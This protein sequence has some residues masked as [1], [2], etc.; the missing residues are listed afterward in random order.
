MTVFIDASFLIALFNKEDEFY[1][2]AK[3]IVQNLEVKATQFVTSNIALAEAVNLLF[4]LKGAS[5]AKR[6]LQVFKRSGIE[7]IFVGREVFAKAYRLLFSEK[8]KRGLNLFD[9]LHLATMKVLKIKTILSF[10]R[11]FKRQKVEVMG[12]KT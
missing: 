1:P 8:T 9:C 7:E 4:R 10:D 12:I 5:V 2:K 3:K 11:D 6:L